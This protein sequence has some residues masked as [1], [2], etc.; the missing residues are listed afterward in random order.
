[1]DPRIQGQLALNL[2]TNTYFPMTLIP[3]GALDR[4]TRDELEGIVSV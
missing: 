1:M 4:E 3:N 2:K